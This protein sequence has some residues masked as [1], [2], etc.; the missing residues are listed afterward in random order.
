MGRF[1]WNYTQRGR[2]KEGEREHVHA[3]VRG[4]I[5]LGREKPMNMYWEIAL[6]LQ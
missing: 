5:A 3:C 2:G 6:S 4:A 1:V